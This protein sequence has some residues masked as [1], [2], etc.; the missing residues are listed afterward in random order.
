MGRGNYSRSRGKTVPVD[1]KEA[2]KNPLGNFVEQAM[3]RG[4]RYQPISSLI[5]SLPDD[6]QWTEAE[7]K[8]WLTALVSNLD[9]CVEVTDKS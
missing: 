1:R 9:Y 5:N 4:Q 8:R 3:Q 2:N 7:R 6:G